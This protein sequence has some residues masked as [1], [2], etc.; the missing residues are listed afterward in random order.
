[1]VEEVGS[2][3]TD[4]TYHRTEVKVGKW[5]IKTRDERDIESDVTV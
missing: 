4:D 3:R 2:E 1:M 5:M